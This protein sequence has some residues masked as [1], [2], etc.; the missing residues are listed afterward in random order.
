MVTTTPAARQNLSQVA[1]AEA[2]KDVPSHNQNIV[3]R[4]KVIELLLNSGDTPL[5]REEFEKINNIL[6][7]QVDSS[8][9]SLLLPHNKWT[10]NSSVAGGAVVRHSLAE[11]TPAEKGDETTS[12]DNSMK[13]PKSLTRRSPI[14]AIAKA[15]TSEDDQPLSPAVTNNGL[16]PFR[17][18]DLATSSPNGSVPPLSDPDMDNAD[19]DTQR[20]LSQMD[21]N[22]YEIRQMLNINY[23]ELYEPGAWEELARY[24]GIKCLYFCALQFSFFL[25]KNLLTCFQILRPRLRM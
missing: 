19:K 4:Q 5:S 7:A 1:A 21:Q 22:T 10:S 8:A 13:A 25:K 17:A 20:F 23:D 24:K 9:I 18:A 11:A 3:E 14:P 12:S 6:L 2:H 15:D 16:P